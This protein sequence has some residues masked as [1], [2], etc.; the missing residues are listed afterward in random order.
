MEAFRVAC[1]QN[2]AEDDLPRNLERL[3]VAVAHARAAGADWVCLPEYFGLMSPTDDDARARAG[4]EEAHPVL[5]WAR[6]AAREHAVWL[7]AGSIAVRQPNGQVRNRSLLVSPE[8]AVVARYDKLHLF[9]VSLAGGEQY[10]ESRCVEPGQEAVVAGLPWGRVGLS[11]CYDLRFAHLYRRLA[12]AGADFLTVPAAFTR[13]TG[14]AHW[15]VLLRARAIETGCW[16]IA[17]AQCGVR[18]WG[19]ATWGHSMVVDP[20]GRIEAALGHEPGLLLADIDPRRVTEARTRI[21]ALCHD[22]PFS[23]P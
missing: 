10:R 12:Q 15:E 3:T 4:P 1:I 8:G 13:T 18:H 22:R 14:Q 2:C 6:A 20:W 7:L 9:D 23:G 19:R 11:I 17:P 21:P 5:D 16:V